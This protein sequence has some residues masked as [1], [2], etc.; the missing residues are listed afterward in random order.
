MLHISRETTE[1]KLIRLV[2]LR[3]KAGET[4][5]AMRDC[6]MDAVYDAYE[7]AMAILNGCIQEVTMVQVKSMAVR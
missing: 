4:L 5:T 6:G 7:P 2:E 3:M 1:Q